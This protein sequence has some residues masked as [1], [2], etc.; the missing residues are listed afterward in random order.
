V[1]LA[2]LSVPINPVFIITHSAMS[3]EQERKR[4]GVNSK[5]KERSSNAKERKGPLEEK[6]ARERKRAMMTIEAF[7]RKRHLYRPI[8]R[9]SV[10]TISKSHDSF[11]TPEMNLKPKEWDALQTN[12]WWVSISDEQSPSTEPAFYASSS[13]ANENKL[14]ISFSDLLDNPAGLIAISKAGLKFDAFLTIAQGAPF[15]IND[16][17]K[18]LRLTEQKLTALQASRKS[19]NQAETERIFQIAQL[20]KLGEQV[21]GNIENFALW[22]MTPSLVLE[23]KKPK[24][25]LDSAFGIQLLTTELH[26]IEYGILA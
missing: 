22:V 8:N 3:K 9:V 23:G 16:W 21:L 24:D 14:V 12:Q 18:F 19:F 2:I 17:V 1:S 13:P 5:W 10:G 7:N 4:A 6:R 20:Q 11:L 26:R 15:S 25:F